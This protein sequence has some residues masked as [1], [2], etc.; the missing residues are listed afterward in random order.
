M[1]T[2]PDTAPTTAPPSDAPFT[3]LADLRAAHSALMR[4]V[5]KDGREA[6]LARVA[7]FITRAQQAGTVIASEADRDSAQGVIDYW[8]AWQFSADN[9]ESL[10]A[11]PPTLAEYVPTEVVS[12]KPAENPYVGLRAF[13]EGD[14]GLFIGR[15]EATRSLLDKVQA[16]PVVFVSGPLGSGK[17]SL[18]F[19]GVV[20]RLRARGVLA[21]RKE[22][23]FPVVIP[24]ADPLTA[25]L[26][27]I[28]QVA[29][30]KPKDG[31][32]WIAQQLPRLQRTPALLA[33]IAGT[34][35]PEA[36][37]CLI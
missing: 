34:V 27:A 9:R 26:T 2:A 33:E 11:A 36:A 8:A 31:E 30:L 25:L 20:P 5:R 17:S 22:P 32:A 21:S 6:S 18:V 15:E 1:E 24:G 12:A 4:D 29:T 37:I 28:L 10:S 14:T 35:A 23:L 7:S 3:C 16:S 19:A 13:E